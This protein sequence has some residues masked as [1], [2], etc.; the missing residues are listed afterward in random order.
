MSVSI[1]EQILVTRAVLET[2]ETEQERAERHERLLGDIRKYRYALERIIGQLDH[3]RSTGEVAKARR[4]AEDALA[5]ATETEAF[6][7]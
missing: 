3:A 2:L 4:L 1:E 7:E 6:P 5:L